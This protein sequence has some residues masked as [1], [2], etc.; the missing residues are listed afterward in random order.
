MVKGI[1]RI[2]DILHN[3]DMLAGDITAQVHDHADRT[4]ADGCVAV[5]GNGDELDSVGDG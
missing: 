3:Q 2:N 5:T 4:A 1:S